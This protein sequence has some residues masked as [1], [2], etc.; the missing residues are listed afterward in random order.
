M[1]L[2][3]LF[4]IKFHLN[5]FKRPYFIMY[6]SKDHIYLAFHHSGQSLYTFYILSITSLHFGELVAS[7]PDA[8]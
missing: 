4:V 5:I 7:T 8:L 1:N 2:D 6:L 3:Y